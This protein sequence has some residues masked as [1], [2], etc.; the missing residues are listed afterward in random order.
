M[1]ANTPGLERYY[2][3]DGPVGAPV[4][5]RRLP[6]VGLPLKP[7]DLGVAVTAADLAEGRTWP[8]PRTHDRQR[9]LDLLSLAADG[10]LTPWVT[11]P[12][13]TNRWAAVV[14]T[15][16]VTLLSSPLPDATPRAAELRSTAAGAYSDMLTYGRAIVV[17]VAGETLAEIDA[18]FAFP[19]AGV[20]DG[21]VVWVPRISASA[22]TALADMIDILVIADGTVAGVR[23]RFTAAP[24]TE[25]VRGELGAL[26][27]VFEPRPAVAASID[28]L[29][30]RNG[31]GRPLLPAALGPI[32][33]IV[34]RDAGISYSRDLNENPLFTVEVDNF[35]AEKVAHQFGIPIEVDDPTSPEA[36]RQ[37]GPQ[38]RSLPVLLLYNGLRRPQYVQAT[39]DM[40]ASFR[41]LDRK[42]LEL[43]ALTAVVPVEAADTGDVGS[44]VALA[45][46]NA[47]HTER[48]RVA[49]YAI[50]TAYVALG[51]LPDPSAWPFVDTAAETIPPPTGRPPAIP[52][53]AA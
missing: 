22:D 35:D 40:E 50:V 14:E 34:R 39:D 26:V 37:L 27:E 9:R 29:T 41:Y 11:V 6:P 53:A 44:G 15:G 5:D 42:E 19:I 4:G 21:W 46:R 10:I 8:P 47:A 52:P 13:P 12:N 2:G 24:V 45:R 30:T 20:T 36:I 48:V 3:P 18:R 38:L 33:E 28:R 16:Q 32:I 17:D 43:T 23:R 31:W 25:P 49:H 1:S 7:V 51:L